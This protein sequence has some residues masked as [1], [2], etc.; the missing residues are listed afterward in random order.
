MQKETDFPKFFFPILTK[1]GKFDEN[2]FRN[3]RTNLENKHLYRR[4][5][6]CLAVVWLEFQK[7]RHKLFRIIEVKSES[8]FMYLCLYMLTYLT[9]IASSRKQTSYYAFLLFFR[10]VLLYFSLFLQNFLQGKIDR[11]FFYYLQLWL[12][13]FRRKKRRKTLKCKFQT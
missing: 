10:P 4:K 2:R 8:F 5:S 13:I 1:N 9:K 11:F 7:C 3:E 6:V 12:C